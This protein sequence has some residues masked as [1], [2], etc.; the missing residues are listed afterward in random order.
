MILEPFMEV[1]H[2]CEVPSHL[3]LRETE[4]LGS[5]EAMHLELGPLP[6]ERLGSSILLGSL[7]LAISLPGLVTLPGA[8]LRASTTDLGSLAKGNLHNGSLGKAACSWT[9]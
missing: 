9:R 6:A 4:A 8:A 1:Q 5:F 2:G 3:I 7:P